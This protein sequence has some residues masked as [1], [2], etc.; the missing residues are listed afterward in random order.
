MA[1]RLEGLEAVTVATT[2]VVMVVVKVA[3]P[4]LALVLL[5]EL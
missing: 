4:V 2:V 1:V 3:W 5:D